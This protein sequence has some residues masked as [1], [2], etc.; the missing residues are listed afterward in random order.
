MHDE[1]VIDMEMTRP[2]RVVKHL[3]KARR[4]HNLPRRVVAAAV[5]K[6]LASLYRWEKG[7]CL[8]SELECDGIENAI[9][10]IE[11]GSLADYVTA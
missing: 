9:A 3:A 5:G 7:L 2:E 6:S 11:A 8:P 10:E 4:D 1:E